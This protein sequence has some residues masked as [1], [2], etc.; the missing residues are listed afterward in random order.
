MTPWHSQV[1][2]ALAKKKSLIFLGYGVTPLVS[3]HNRKTAR[4][5]G[6]IAIAMWSSKLLAEKINVRKDF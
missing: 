3:K 4:S 5:T 1:L 6:F 2:F